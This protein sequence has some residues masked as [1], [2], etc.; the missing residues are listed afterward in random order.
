MYRYFAAFFHSL[1]ILYDGWGHY[2]RLRFSLEFR[3][4][5][6]KNGT[7]C[8][9]EPIL[10]YRKPLFNG[11]RKTA[12]RMF[13]MGILC[14]IIIPHSLIFCTGCRANIYNSFLNSFFL[15][16]IKTMDYLEWQRQRH[17]LDIIFF[18]DSLSPYICMYVCHNFGGQTYFLINFC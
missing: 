11:L 5:S 3:Y 15:I 13:I 16:W 4:W 14:P 10:L 9:F 1:T 6:Y 18:I 2:A 8:C 12:E 7:T 17:T